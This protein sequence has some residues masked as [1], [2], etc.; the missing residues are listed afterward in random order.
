MTSV[1]NRLFSRDFS[2]AAR[3]RW[4]SPF[5]TAL[6][7]LETASRYACLATVASCSSIILS[8]FLIDERNVERWLML[9]RRR[10]VFCRARL[11]AWDELAKGASSRIPMSSGVCEYVQ[12]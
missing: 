3:L 7:I 5:D 9:C 6:S 12:I 2:R 8:S 4:C 11:R 1:R 10:F